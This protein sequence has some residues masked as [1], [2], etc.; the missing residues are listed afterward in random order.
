MLVLTRKIGE[1]LLIGEDIVLTV[2]DARGDSVR[3][4]IDVPRGVPIQRSEVLEAVTAAN[5][6]AA[7][8]DAG[9]EER[10]RGILGHVLPAGVPKP[11]HAPDASPAPGPKSQETKLPGPTQAHT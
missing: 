10:I 1:K 6:S 4:G 5:I 9:A 11:A 3:I 2:L 7:Q 8:T